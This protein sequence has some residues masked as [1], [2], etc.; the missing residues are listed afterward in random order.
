MR[1][2]SNGE[3]RNENDVTSSQNFVHHR[4]NSEQMDDDMTDAFWTRNSCVRLASNK[5]RFLGAR[6]CGIVPEQNE[7]KVATWNLLA[8][9]YS[10]IQYEREQWRARLEA[11]QRELEKVD[12]DIAA[13][14]E[15]WCANEE[16]VHLWSEWATN[17]GYQLIILPRTRGKED[18]CATLIRI[19]ACSQIEAY[20]LSYDDWGDRVCLIVK[21]APEI[22]V[23][24]THWTFSHNNSWDPIMRKHQ[25]RKL[26]DHLLHLRARAI[27]ILGDLNGN[28][29]D[30]ALVHFAERGFR[31]YEPEATDWVSHYAHTNKFLACDFLSTRGLNVKANSLTLHGQVV[32]LTPKKAPEFRVSDHL[33]LSA[34]VTGLAHGSLSFFEETP[35]PGSTGKDD[36]PTPHSSSSS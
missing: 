30:P 11:Q 27:L 23:C 32:D 9:P 26:A 31:F 6:S 7:L 19:K 4:N 18:G 14:Q 15:F 13:L 29:K 8:P 28:Q 22:F 3:G 2:R 16:A 12:A 21:I 24:N 5:V 20:A 35:T 36:S 33:L 10:R 25:A 34:T 1:F 17:K